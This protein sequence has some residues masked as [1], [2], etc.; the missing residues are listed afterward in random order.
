MVRA[1]ACALVRGPDRDRLARTSAR[2]PFASEVE[3]T[4]RPGEAKGGQAA[5]VG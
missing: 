5:V 3:E 2:R 1:H 4:D